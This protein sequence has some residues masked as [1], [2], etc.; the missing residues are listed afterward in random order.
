MRPLER[1]ANV[2][3][4]VVALS[5]ESRLGEVAL[6]A[7]REFALDVAGALVWSAVLLEWHLRVRRAAR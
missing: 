3:V 4:E 2:A 1:I 6:L 5:S 7:A